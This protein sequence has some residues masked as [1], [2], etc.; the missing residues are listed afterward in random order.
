MIILVAPSLPTSVSAP[1]FQSTFCC[2]GVQNV[3]PAPLA[4]C[5]DWFHLVYVFGDNQKGFTHQIPTATFE[6]LQEMQ[7]CVARLKPQ[8]PDSWW[9]KPNP[10]ELPKTIGY[11]PYLQHNAGMFSLGTLF[12]VATT[13]P[14]LLRQ[15]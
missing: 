14:K 12:A 10:S 13:G 9:P 6:T 3:A 8:S 7:L 11:Q 5:D 15:K 1:L 4:S 2:T